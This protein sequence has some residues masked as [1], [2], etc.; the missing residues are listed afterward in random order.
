MYDKKLSEENSE[1]LKVKIFRN[2]LIYLLLNLTVGTC[3]S[4]KVYVE[5][6]EGRYSTM[7]RQDVLGVVVYLEKLSTVTV[8]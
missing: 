5:I 8:L 2:L 3:L 7:T 4:R 1:G 6:T